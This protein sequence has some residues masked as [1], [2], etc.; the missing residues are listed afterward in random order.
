MAMRRGAGCRRNINL[1]GGMHVRGLATAHDVFLF[2]DSPLGELPARLEL[3]CAANEMRSLQIIVEATREVQ[4]SIND[5]QF[6]LEVYEMRAVPVE[7]NTGDGVE[8]GG[9]MVI[10]PDQCPP[11]AIRRA[12]FWVYDCLSPCTDGR[13]PARDGR[14]ALYCCVRPIEPMTPGLHDLTLTLN[15][16]GQMTRISLALKAYPVSIPKEHFSV[17]NWYSE[18]AIS[19]F[20]ATT[21]GTPQHEAMRYKYALAM[22]RARQTHVLVSFTP[23]CVTGSDPWTFDFSRQREQIATFKRAGIKGLTLGCMLSRGSLPDGTP[24]MYTDVFRCALRPDI[25]FETEAGYALSVRFCQAVAAFL[26]ENGWEHDV[27]FQ[28]HDEP[29]VHYRGSL[30]ARR[31]QYFLAASL[32]RRYI[33]GVQIC[34]AVS[35]TAFAGGIDIWVPI[36]TGYE[37]QRTEF[38][39]LQALGEQVWSY[40]CCGPEG[41][42]LNRFLDSPLIRPRLLFWGFAAYGISGYLHWGFNQFHDGMD[43]FKGTSCP[44]NTGIGTSFPCGDAFIVY[45]GEQGPLLSMRLEAQRRGAQDAELLGM[46][47]SRDPEAAARIIGRVFRSNSDYCEDC[48]TF[49]ANY[50]ELLNALCTS[51]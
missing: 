19:R 2:P 16:D 11:Y 4:M 12:P 49:E 35:G 24:D 39:R 28:I 20:H 45:P 42:Y 23:E 50:A 40:V 7:Y 51:K 15:C 36:T 14:A 38:E 31:R 46:L 32:L 30:D 1:I 48:A 3:A 10:S 43:P 25:D 6:E 47:K 27:S 8:Q 17:I 37:K 21:P 22:R 29:D 41:F 9:A 26:R 44:N 18:R 5:A 34:E 13:V 33:P